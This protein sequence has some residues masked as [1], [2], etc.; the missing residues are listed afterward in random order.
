MKGR[1]IYLR[2]TD[3][4]QRHWQRILWSIPDELLYEL[5][6]GNKVEIID[7]STKIHGKIERICIPVLLDILRYVWFQ[8]PPLFKL[9]TRHYQDALQI[10]KTDTLLYSKYKYWRNLNPFRI[11]LLA[12]TLQV[13][14]ELNPIGV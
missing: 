6:K 1:K 3:I 5:A 4:E 13:E 10:L 7:Q 9:Y 12:T 8:E 2:S 14:R 11:D